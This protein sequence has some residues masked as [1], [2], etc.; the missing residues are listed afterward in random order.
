MMEGIYFLVDVNLFRVLF[1]LMVFVKVF[2]VFEVVVFVVVEL[3]V[4]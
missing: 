2:L 3:I 1:V 4:L